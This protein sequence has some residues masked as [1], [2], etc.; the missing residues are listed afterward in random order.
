MIEYALFTDSG[1]RACNEDAVAI[2]MNLQTKTYGFF[3]ADGLGGHGNGAAASKLVTDYFCAAIENTTMVNG[4]FVAFC[5]DSAQ[6]TLLE[7]QQK[8]GI[9]DGMKTTLV[10][11]Y[12]QEN[13]AFWGHIGDSRLY[14]FREN[15]VIYHTP[16]HSVPQMLVFSGEIDESEIRHHPD[17][18]RL[19]YAF[20]GAWY[21]PPPYELTLMDGKLIPGDVFLLCSDGFWEWIEEKEMERVLRKADCIQDALKEMQKIIRKNGKGQDLDNL[22]AILVKYQ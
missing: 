4:D 8:K 16:D 7:E 9:A 13:D 5:F 1:E 21:E 12:V 6:Q 10:A 20:G 3:L 17:R 22:S 14:M 19:L 18:N 15:K 2:S 11:L